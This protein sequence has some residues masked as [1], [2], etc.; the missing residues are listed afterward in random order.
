MY[1]STDFYEKYNTSRDFYVISRKQKNSRGNVQPPKILYIPIVKKTF[2]LWW[3]PYL[4][5]P[6]F[7]VTILSAIL[8][9]PMLKC[10]IVAVCVTILLGLI[11]PSDAVKSIDWQLVILIACSFAVGR[12]VLKSGLAD[13]FASLVL[14]ANVPT[15]LLPCILFGMVQ[16]ITGLITNNAAVTLFF[17]LAISLANTYELSARPFAI[18]VTVGASAN[19]Y[20]SIGY[21][22][23]LMVMGPANYT[24]LNFFVIGLPLSL[25]LWATCSLFIPLIW[26]LH[27]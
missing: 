6:V 17:P 12:A 16:F 7:A 19:F 11:T 10:V 1:G 25:L 15:V 3:W 2:K 5:Y 22:T 4:I 26:P 24:G 14:M 23:N 9:V 21:Q 20:T 18:A 8:G 13:A 27:L